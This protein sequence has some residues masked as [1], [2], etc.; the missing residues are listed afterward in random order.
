MPVAKRRSRFGEVALQAGYIQAMELEKALLVQ[1]E[2]DQHGES[3]K[4]LGII[5]LDMGAISSEQLIEILKKMNET[6]PPA[7]RGAPGNGGSRTN[8]RRA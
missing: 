5:L 3:H 6:P 7:D 8:G 1:R 2:R 4:L